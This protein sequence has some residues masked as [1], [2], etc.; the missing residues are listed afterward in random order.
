[1]SSRANAGLLVAVAAA[2]FLLASAFP[3]ISVGL[4]GY[5]PGCLALL[6]FL[7][8]SVGLAIYAALSRMRL[9]EHSQA[10]EAVSRL[11]EG[12]L[13]LISDCGHSPHI[14]QPE[15][16]VSGLSRFLERKI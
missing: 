5:S 10:K 4:E 2:V 8:A 3:A 9:P 7:A 11:Q 14:E 6:R 16:F 15:R 13:E 1:M 12:P